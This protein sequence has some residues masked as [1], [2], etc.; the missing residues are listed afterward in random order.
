MTMNRQQLT[1]T[2]LAL[3]LGTSAARAQE[4]PAGSFDQLR[5]AAR[6]GETLTVIDQSGATTTGKLAALTASELTLI[7]GKSRRDLVQS[8]VLTITRHGHGDLAKGARWGFA[9]GAGIG[10]MAGLYWNS[11]CYGCGSLIPLFTATYA[12]LGAG[13]GL[14]AAAITPTRSVIYSAAGDVRRRVAVSPIAAPS[15]FGAALSIAF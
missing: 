1:A 4:V 5:L 14:G 2:C 8:D 9:I 10:L 11:E 6:L 7:V 12:S 15:R 13:L 3:F